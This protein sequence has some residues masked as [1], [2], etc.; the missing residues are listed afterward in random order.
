MSNNNSTLQQIE[1]FSHLST[2]QIFELDKITKVHHYEKNEIVFYEGDESRNFNIL[3]VGEISVFKSLSSTETTEIHR[4]IAPSL[5]AEVATLKHIPYPASAQC[6]SKST[7]LHI[8]RVP[9]LEL[10]RNDAG[11]SIG[12]I[13]SLTQKIGTLEH[14]LQY[15][16]APTALAKVTRL[17]RDDPHIFS[18]LKGIEIAHRLA[19]TPETLSRTLKKLKQEKVISLSKSTDIHIHDFI[20]LESYC[21]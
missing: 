3:I 15:H 12:L 7:L 6:L 18:R 10:L 13:A 1:L 16:T 4:F 21:G 9:F 17:L 11:L 8:E 14:A 20:K 19:I 2:A 5:I